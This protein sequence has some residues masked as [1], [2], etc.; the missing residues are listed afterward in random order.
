MWSLDLEK[1]YAPQ[2]QGT[3][4][5]IGDSMGAPLDAEN[6]VVALESNEF[7]DV[8]DDALRYTESSICSAH[9]TL[10]SKKASLTS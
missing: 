7:S 4:Y 5:A 6:G 9:W 8:V 10:W 2:Y 1:W 3:Y